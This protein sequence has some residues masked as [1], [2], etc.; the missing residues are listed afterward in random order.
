MCP[1]AKAC[2]DAVCFPQKNG[3]EGPMNV[4]RQTLAF[5]TAV[6][7][8]RH[9]KR[10]RSVATLRPCRAG[11]QFDESVIPVTSLFYVL[12]KRNVSTK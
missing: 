9:K 2:C 8:T 1:F 10:T 6:L 4:L 5:C 3:V 12:F 11:Q 7:C